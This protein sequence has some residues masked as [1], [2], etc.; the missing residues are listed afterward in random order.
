MLATAPRYT[1]I[2][3]AAPDAIAL[4]MGCV[5]DRPHP[6][7]GELTLR[8]I[9]HA[10]G[11]K[12]R[13]Q[14]G[15]SDASVVARGMGSSDFAKLL[16]DGVGLATVAAY[17]AA[18]S[19][20]LQVCSILE[21]KD[22]KQESTPALDGDLGLRLLK[23]FQPIE[24]VDVFTAAGGTAQLRTYGRLCI[25]SRTTIFNDTLRALQT[26]FSGAGSN[27]AQ[28]EASLL[29]QALND[30]PTLDD[31]AAVFS[32]ANS[33]AAALADT[34]LGSAMAL[35]RNEKNAAGN[36]LNLQA[37]HLLVD[38]GQE[39]AARKFV[40]DAALNIEVCALAGLPSG[41]WFLLPS[42]AVHPV[43]GLLRLAGAKSP[44]RVKQERG[45]DVDGVLV[46]LTADTG[47]SILRRS[48]IVRGGADLA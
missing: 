39:Y 34:S 27:V 8:K 48:G 30:N 15:E 31:G 25:I 44:L 37:R 17:D 19:E 5:L 46:L 21:T 42:P 32:A 22:F 23:E 45:F 33:V 7:A 41:R 28:L 12:S 11:Q 18:S 43:V 35:L 40:R 14:S 16:A 29:A 4:K 26:V 38:P 36:P 6:L 13:P 20:Y 47:V 24:Q 2:L 1:E 10:A 3:S 9:A